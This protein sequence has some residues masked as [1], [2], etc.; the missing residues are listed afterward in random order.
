M[1]TSRRHGTECLQLTG[2]RERVARRAHHR[3]DA[4]RDIHTVHEFE[5][6]RLR[7]SSLR[8][9]H[10]HAQRHEIRAFLLEESRLHL[11]NR[12]VA[13]HDH[14]ALHVHRL[15]VDQPKLADRFHDLR[16][17]GVPE[18]LVLHRRDLPLVAMRH[19]REAAGGVKRLEFAHRGIELHR[20]DLAERRHLHALAV[21]HDE[22]ER[23]VV[24]EHPL[25]GVHDLVLERARRILR[26]SADKDAHRLGLV[27]AITAKLREDVHHARRESAVGHDG[28]ALRG[29][30]RAELLLLLHDLRVAAEIAEVRAGRNR[31]FGHREVEVVRQRTHHRA[32]TGHRRRHRRRILH[33]ESDQLEA[34]A[35]HV[36]LQELRK[37][38]HGAIRQTNFGNRIILEQV[39][40]TGRTLQAGAEY[41]HPHGYS[42]RGVDFLIASKSTLWAGSFHPFLKPADDFVAQQSP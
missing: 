34:F 3:A 10:H 14:R 15:V 18:R 2:D 26:Q 27:E 12:H 24:V 29:S 5:G 8:S 16:V 42:I 33:V 40:S 30:L 23:R 38:L 4:V 28:D 7:L 22:A 37:V 32:H 20:L 41:K 9:R 21:A 36:G 25:D 6:V 35:A 39:I 1:H 31:G 13:R 11:R 17:A 19:R